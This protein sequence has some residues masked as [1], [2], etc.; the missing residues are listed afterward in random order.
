MKAALKAWTRGE[1]WGERKGG[2]WGS[3]KAA[4]K[5]WTRGLN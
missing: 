5:A 4:L 1:R 3:R 2:R